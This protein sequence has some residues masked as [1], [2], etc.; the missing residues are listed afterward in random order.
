MTELNY[1]VAPQT[2]LQ[3]LQAGA[4]NL[5]TAYKTLPGQPQRLPTGGKMCMS[6]ITNSPRWELVKSF[7]P[8]TLLSRKQIKSLVYFINLCNA[9]L[10]YLG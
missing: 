1:L 10:I 4:H 8:F 2:D 9:I 7:I 6:V 5:S 3:N